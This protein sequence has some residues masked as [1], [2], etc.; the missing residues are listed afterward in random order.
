LPVAGSLPRTAVVMNFRLRRDK[1]LRALERE[2]FDAFLVTHQANV[3]YLC[4]FTGSAGALLVAERGCVFFT[5]GRYAQQVR[6]EVKAARLIVSSGPL[7]AAVA[8]GVGNAVGRASRG[9]VNLGFESDHMSVAARDVLKGLLPRR[10]RLHGASGTVEKLRAV[11]DPQ[12][13]ECLRHAA[14]VGASLLDSA[15]AAIRPGIPETSIAAELEYAARHAGAQGMSFDTIVAAGSRSALPHGR[16][17]DQP[18][19]RRGFVVLD[20]GVILR[21]YCSDLT[22][23]VHLGRPGR[24][25]RA[26]Y[27]AVREAQLAAIGAVRAGAKTSLVDQAARRSLGRVGLARFFTHSTGHGVGLEV[28]EQPRLARNA[29][30]CLE[31]GMVI[32]IEPGVYLPGKGG[33]RIEDMVLVTAS[34]GEVLTTAPKELIQL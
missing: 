28:H 5:D 15:L 31:A 11:K 7:L 22:R 19:P 3:H 16:A 6:E 17:S 14:Q 25:M 2:N 24:D 9:P 27:E 30:G 21:S 13:I 18:I 34:G 29:G 4:G 33:V 12:E 1:L 20:F 10:T 8:A 32:T 26:V 23:T